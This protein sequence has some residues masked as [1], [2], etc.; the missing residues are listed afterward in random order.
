MY[1]GGF[2]PLITRP[3]RVT[4]ASATLI[5]NIYSNQI[6]DGDHSLSVVMLTGITDHNIIFHI[7]N[8]VH[9]QDVEY[10]ITRRNYTTRNKDNFISQLSNIDWAGVLQSD[11]TQR[12]FSLFQNKMRSLHDNC[13]ILLYISKIYN[14]RKPWLSDTLRDAVK[15]KNKLYRNSIKI[16]T[17]YNEMVNKN[18]HYKLRHL[19]KA[20]EK[21]YYSDLV[22]VNKSNS[23][24]M[25]SI[26]KNMINRNK[27]VNQY[28]KFNL[29]IV[30]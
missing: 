28:K 2:I 17:V 14:T 30:R 7:A 11:S 16:E 9:A 26:I 3:T 5:D 8:N 21:K 12:A 24:K 20:A 15:K 1:S 23:T 27:K 19:L 18:Y 25:W 6:L 13:F 4:H 29:A 10:S 22:Q